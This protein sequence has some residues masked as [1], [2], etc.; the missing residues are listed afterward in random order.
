MAT[1]HFTDTGPEG[2]PILKHGTQ[3]RA[4]IFIAR[5]Y[6]I[7]ANRRVEAIA[8]VLTLLERAAD[9]DGHVTIESVR[10]I[11]FLL[12]EQADKLAAA[13]YRIADAFEKLLGTEAEDTDNNPMH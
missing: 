5:Q 11:Q 13:N 2:A 1:H 8:T 12:D 10:N 7:E 9:I 4:E 6:A 3:A